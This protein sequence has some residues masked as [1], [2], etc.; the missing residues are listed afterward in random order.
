MLIYTQ[1]MYTLSMANAAG[2]AT[3]GVPTRLQDGIRRSGRD[4]ALAYLREHVLPDP[5][6]QGT[7][8]N[9]QA[10]AT[11]VGVSRTPVREALLI[12]ASDG[13]VQMLP[14]RGAYIPAITAREIYELFDL[15]GVLE[16]HAANTIITGSGDPVSGLREII[17]D[18]ERIAGRDGHGLDD[19]R[20]FIDADRHFHQE[21]VDAAGSALL[22]R[23]YA[24]LRD[25]Q[26]RA[27]VAAMLKR[28]SRWNDVCAEH[29]AIVDALSTRDERR[30]HTM[31]DD[32]LRISLQTLLTA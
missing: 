26:L 12:L 21:L 22:S 15:R 10:I 11:E 6:R 20:E 18:Q 2:T 16:R 13:L 3:S 25:R 19:A 17:S 27:G 4:R 1:G 32:H 24:G 8:V 14:Q 7:F 28:A 23:T 30:L 31:I 5:G 29:T 9:E